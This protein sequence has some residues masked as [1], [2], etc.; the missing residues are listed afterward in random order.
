MTVVMLTENDLALRT[1]SETGLMFLGKHVPRLVSYFRPA[2][3]SKKNG[4]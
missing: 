1:S 3:I 4:F 2:K